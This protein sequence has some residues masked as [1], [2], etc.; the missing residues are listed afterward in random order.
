V[1]TITPIS[2]VVQ[3][4]VGIYKWTTVWQPL[5]IADVGVGVAINDFLRSEPRSMTVT[6]PIGV[7]AS[8]VF[9]GSNDNQNFAPLGDSGLYIPQGYQSPLFPFP[10][11]QLLNNPL[12][13]MLGASSHPAYIRPNCNAGDMAAR[14]I[15]TFVRRLPYK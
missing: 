13:V 9:E 4:T 12:H 7:V 10:I 14:F 3:E 5:S 15:V 2:T 11:D 1:A 8:V 6:D